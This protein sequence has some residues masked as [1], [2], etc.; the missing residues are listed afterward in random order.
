MSAIHYI[1]RP[2][3]TRGV[4]TVGYEVDGLFYP[5]AECADFGRSSEEAERT[6][7]QIVEALN[8]CAPYNEPAFPTSGALCNHQ[9]TGA[10]LRDYFAAKALPAVI[11]KCSGD[12]LR[13]GEDRTDFFARV[14]YELADAMLKARQ[15]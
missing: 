3:L 14:S 13:E 9:F 7:A 2:W 12:T 11:E 8:G 4:T 5:I 15:S 6:A 1:A 10:S